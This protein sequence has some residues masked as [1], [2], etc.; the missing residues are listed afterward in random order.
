MFNRETKT[1]IRML[2]ASLRKPP[3]KEWNQLLPARFVL[4]TATEQNMPPQQNNT[5]PKASHHGQISRDRVIPVVSRYHRTQPFA[6]FMHFVVHPL[7][8]F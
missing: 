6:G 4:S 7:A 3:I 5:M 2:I 1:R 8:Q